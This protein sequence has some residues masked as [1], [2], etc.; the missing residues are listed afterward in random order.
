MKTDSSF[1]DYVSL[2]GEIADEMAWDWDVAYFSPM[3][4]A[5]SIS[6]DSSLTG[7]RAWATQ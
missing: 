7:T 2:R 4:I 6:N 3:S 5:K 1:S